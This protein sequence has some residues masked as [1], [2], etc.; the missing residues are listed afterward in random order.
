VTPQAPGVAESKPISDSLKKH[1]DEVL[2][3]IP[4][5]KTGQVTLAVSNTGAVASIGIK[6]ALGKVDWTGS[7]YAGK[8]WGASGWEAGVRSTFAF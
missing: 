5:G 2:T 4:S 3:Q 7:G 8:V 6:R 1:L